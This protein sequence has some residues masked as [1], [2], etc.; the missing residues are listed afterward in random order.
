M[1][2]STIGSCAKLSIGKI[3]WKNV[4]ISSTNYGISVINMTKQDITKLQCNKN[5]ICR[6]IFGAENYTQWAALALNFSVKNRIRE[7]QFKYIRYV[8]EAGNYLIK[9]TEV[10]VK[11]LRQQNGCMFF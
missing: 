5:E 7:G 1:I 11:V 6:Q 10:E 3:Y 4:A 9:S 2:Y 8:L